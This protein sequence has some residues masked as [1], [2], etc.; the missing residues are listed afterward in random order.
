MKLVL[1][2]LA[3]ALLPAA[4][5]AGCTLNYKELKSAIDVARSEVSAK[6]KVR[7]SRS[8]RTV[9]Q[10]ITRK[11]GQVVRYQAGGCEHYTYSFAY[12]NV[13]LSRDARADLARAA[14]LL[15]ATPVTKAGAYDRDLLLSNLR[16]G[17]QLGEED[18]SVHY[19][20]CGDATCTVSEGDAGEF[21]V[22][23]SFAL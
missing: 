15:E 13:K 3:L 14:D 6:S 16:E 11:D 1:S 23:Y 10:S 17:A 8:A 19:F 5:Q 7:Y 21:V 12:P 20:P 4:A 22:G 9:S 2:L 18:G